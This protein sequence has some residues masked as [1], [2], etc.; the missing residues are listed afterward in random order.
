MI[1]TLN[2][3]P[4]EV[5]LE[6]E[7]TVRELLMGL[8]SWL[9]EHACSVSSLNIDGIEIPA[10]EIEPISQRA[11]DSVARIDLRS[12][13]LQDLKREALRGVSTWLA[14]TETLTGFASSPAL[15]F[16]ANLDGE[17]GVRL[18]AIV[19]DPSRTEAGRL[20]DARDFVAGME[21]EFDHSV[22]EFI[23]TSTMLPSMADRLEALPL[24]LQT[25]QDV[26]A[27][28][29][30]RDFSDLS[31]KLIRLLPL[32]GH[33]GVN[34]ASLRIG[35]NNIKAF[36]DELASALKELVSAFESGDAILVGDLSEYEIAPR[37]RALEAAIAIFPFR[38]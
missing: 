34:L 3:D 13:S 18:G 23:A 26:H 5:V 17:M 35:E 19:L 32:I 4:L 12:S 16:L 31:G 37:L 30:L 36:F 15:T 29:T 38:A 22:A 10:L 27:A 9:E 11:L 8:E 7:R 6:D 24:Q 1:V 33:T 25:G 2:G 28:E 20:Q 21:C 14:A